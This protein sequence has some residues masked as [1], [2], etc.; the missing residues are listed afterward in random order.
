MSRAN[1]AD[2]FPNASW[3]SSGIDKINAGNPKL[4]PFFSD[5]VDLGG[6][7]YFNEDGLGYVGVS[8]FTKRVVGFTYSSNLTMGVADAVALTGV[9][10]GTPGVGSRQEQIDANP[11]APVTISTKLTADGYTDVRGEELVWVQ[12][13]D[14][15]IEGLGFDI[16]ATHITQESSNPLAEV[17]GI[18]PWAYN[19]TASYDYKDLS[20]RATYYHQ[21]KAKVTGPIDNNYDGGAGH[22]PYR[23]QYALARSQVDLSASYTL[24]FKVAGDG[25]LTVTLDV[26]NLTKEPVG[27]W[28][29]YEGVPYQYWNP[30]TTYTLGLRGKF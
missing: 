19:F 2:M 28:V 3:G 23:A 12:P 15:I 27:S 24:P 22:L 4:T 20:L 21:D 30:G 16:S 13:L 8:L 7:W 17:T 14:F 6:E 10:V 29:Q 11:T 26:Y 18:S 1:P 9:Y 25:D 5:S